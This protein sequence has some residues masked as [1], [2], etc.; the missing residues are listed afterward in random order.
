MTI[1]KKKV[2]RI[3]KISVITLYML[4]VLYLLGC[5]LLP[6]LFNTQKDSDEVID[7]VPSISERVCLVDGNMDA[8]I[9]RLRLIQSAKEEII[10]STFDFRN[11]NSGKDIM[12]ALLDASDRGVHIRLLIDGFNGWLQ[13]S[14]SENFETL[15]AHENVEGKFYNPIN[16]TNFWTVNYRLHDKYVLVDNEAYILGGRNTNDL[17]LGCYTEEYNIDRDVVVYEPSGSS[18]STV[19]VLKAYFEETWN[20]DSNKTLDY[21][22]NSSATAFLKEHW[23]ALQEDYAKQL[24]GIDWMS[25]TTETNSVALLT[26]DITPSNK[27][28]LMLNTL[29]E[30]IKTGTESVVIQTPYIICDAEMYHT[31]EDICH[32][33]ETVEIVVNAVGNGANP[34]GCTDYMNEKDHIL[35]VGAALL[36]WSGEQSM[37]TKTVLIDNSVS[38]I[39]SYN[40]DARSTYLDTEMMLIIDSSELNEHIR[41][42]IKNMETQSKR[43]ESDGT[44]STGSDYTNKEMSFFKKTLYWVLRIVVRLFRYLL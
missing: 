7:I 28:P 30:L 37:H 22:E 1:K 26:G 6:P 40:L 5:I 36:E 21:N 13:L 25:E 18:N 9:W 44:E 4:C 27:V 23:S 33:A 8:L 34:W 24:V 35:G 42:G 43:I 38:I 32:N 2:K 31:L 17:F 10:L 3:I 41:I 12:A 11:D 19:T 39:G 15:I 29:S 14:R 20:L 16:V